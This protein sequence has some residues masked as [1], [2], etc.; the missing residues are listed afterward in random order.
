MNIIGSHKYITALTIINFKFPERKRANEEAQFWYDQRKRIESLHSRLNALNGFSSALCHNFI[1]NSTLFSSFLSLSLTFPFFCFSL[2]Y[3]FSL[4]FPFSFFH[5]L[6]LFFFIFLSI[7]Y[8]QCL[9]FVVSGTF[10]TKKEEYHKKARNKLLTLLCWANHFGLGFL[11]GYSE[12][13]GQNNEEN[14][15]VRSRCL[16]CVDCFSYFFARSQYWELEMCQPCRVSLLSHPITIN[17]N[18]NKVTKNIVMFW[19]EGKKR[20]KKE[21]GIVETPRQAY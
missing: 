9:W 3:L 12:N 2:F 4:F 8:S 10:P 1:T 5:F 7:Q 15:E 17:I 20:T 11:P 14:S 21:N 18:T 16:G 6:L 13:E 19:E